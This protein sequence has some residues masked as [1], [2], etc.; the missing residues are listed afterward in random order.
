MKML[1]IYVNE[2]IKKLN[3]ILSWALNKNIY[4]LYLFTN[5]LYKENLANLVKN[6]PD[7]I[8]AYVFLDSESSCNLSRKDLDEC[9][10]NKNNISFIADAI[11][12]V[13]YSDKTIFLVNDLIEKDN[14]DEIINSNYNI[15]ISSE[16][17]YEFSYKINKDVKCIYVSLSSL[18]NS[19]DFIFLEKINDVVVGNHCLV[20]NNDIELSTI[21]RV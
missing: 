8:N 4:S 14:L 12:N 20:K 7:K 5:G 11:R 17:S 15:V 10:N 9:I 2:D 19:N 18:D 13:Y 1:C 3:C 6:I 16:N 21:F